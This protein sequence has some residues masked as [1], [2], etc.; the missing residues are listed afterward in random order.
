MS[1]RNLIRAG[2]CDAVITGAAD[3]LCRLTIGGF[4]AL[5]STSAEICSM[6]YA[7]CFSLHSIHI[8]KNPSFAIHK[9]IELFYR[10]LCIWS[11]VIRD[12]LAILA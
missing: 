2:I 12:R 4:S 9:M 11:A 7:L 3:A 1:A 5:E 10:Q 6:P 8:R